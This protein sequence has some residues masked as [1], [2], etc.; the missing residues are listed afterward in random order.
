MKRNI[1]IT[2]VTVVVSVVVT[3]LFIDASDTLS[4]KGGTLLSS[5][6]GAK[7]GGCPQG[8]VPVA[9]VT[10][11]CADAYEVSAD[12]ACPH[13]EVQNQLD[14]K[15]NMEDLRCR[16]VS[17]PDTLP[18]AY[19]TRE[20]ARALCAGRNARLPTNAEWYQ[21]ALGARDQKGACNI[22]T[23]ALSRTGSFSACA[24]PSGVFDVIGNAWEWT[25]DDVINGSFNGRTLPESGYVA[26]VDQAGVAVVSTPE[27]QEGFFEDYIWSKT[28]GAFGMIRGGF[29]GSRDD[30]GVFALH[31]ETLPTTAGAAIS[32]RCVQ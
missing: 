24:T 20:Q 2:A 6:I 17:A 25:A 21:L 30:A 5:V 22:D 13:S 32:F 14:T 16:A 27:P 19:V 15:S 4:G 1:T 26:Q 11:A 10:F 29:Y 18:W 7:E 31:A 3:T 23:G 12:S 28:D 8:M 9:G